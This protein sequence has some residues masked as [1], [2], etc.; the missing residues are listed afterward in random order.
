MMQMKSG[1]RQEIAGQLVE[2]QQLRS[3]ELIRIKG[4]VRDEPLTDRQRFGETSLHAYWSN[5]FY[6]THRYALA[7]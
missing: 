4:G 2:N 1:Q 7:F 5:F 6:K 3:D